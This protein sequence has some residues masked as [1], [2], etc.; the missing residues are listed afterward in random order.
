MGFVVDADGTVAHRWQATCDR[1]K[2]VGLTLPA[3]APAAGFVGDSAQFRARVGVW[4]MPDNV[5]DAG[6][7]EDLVRTLVP[8]GDPLIDHAT[9]ATDRAYTLDARF[10]AQDRIKAELHCWLAWQKEPGRPFGTALKAQFL[11][12][13]SDVAMRFVAWFKALFGLA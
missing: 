8:T 6:R 1:L 9:A 12:H 10:P 2:N 4:I 3:S 7:L 13:D 11:R 5:T